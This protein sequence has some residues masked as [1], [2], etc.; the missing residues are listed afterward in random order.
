MKQSGVAM[1]AA[2]KLEGRRDLILQLL[3]SASA[4]LSI[5][6]IAEQ[7]QVHPNTVRFHLDGLIDASR[8]E[9]LLGEA[10]GPG[11]PPV[12]YR[13]SRTMDRGGPTNYRL[14]AAILANHLAASSA[15]P[16]REAIKMGRAW[17]PSLVERPVRHGTATRAGALAQLV[18]VLADLGFQPEAVRGP[19]ATQVRIRHCPFLDLVDDHADVICPLHLG[20]MQGTMAAVNASVTVDRLDAFVEPDLCVAHLTKARVRT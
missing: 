20:L 3:R 9:R 1:P 8:V 11:R 4:P 19:T 5:A 15:D 2:S 18:S 17:A 14:L 16:T 7:L 10:A 12:L 13:M 6:S